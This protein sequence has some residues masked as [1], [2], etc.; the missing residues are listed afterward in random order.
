MNSPNSVG[1]RVAAIRRTS[2]SLWMRYSMRSLIV[3]ILRPCR[4]G[5]VGELGQ[6]RHAAVL[7][8]HLADDAGRVAA[9]QPG[10]VD[11]R[12]GV[13]GAPEHAAGHRAQREDVAGR[14]RSSARIGGVDQGA[15]GDGAVVGRGAG[16][17]AAAGV[18]A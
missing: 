13:A 5:Q 18:D 1:S 7:V 10:E 16:R 3:I 15:D 17:H 11:G 12:L 8:E 2:F 14:V 4:R 6:P 9:G